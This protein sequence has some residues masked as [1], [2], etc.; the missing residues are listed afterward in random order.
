MS[1]QT[2]PLDMSTAQLL[3]WAYYHAD[4]CEKKVAFFLTKSTASYKDE[5]AA[6]WQ[7]W[8]ECYCA[9]AA[10]LETLL[11]LEQPGSTLK[12]VMQ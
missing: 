4:R 11:E 12:S 10:K 7:G 6:N 5:A 8:F 9:V 1:H 2:A 3:Q